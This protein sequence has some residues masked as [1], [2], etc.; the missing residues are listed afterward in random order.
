MNFCRSCETGTGGSRIPLAQ[1]CLSSDNCV[2]RKAVKR[3]LRSI[4]RFPV[5]L[6]CLKTLAMFHSDAVAVTSFDDWAGDF[7]LFHHR[8][9]GRRRHG[10]GYRAHDQ[11]LHRDVALKFLSVDA[12]GDPTAHTNILTEARTISALNHPN[13]CTIYEVGEASGQPYL[14]MEFIEGHTLSLEIT[15]V[16]MAV[17][18]VVRY[19]M[20]L[21]DAL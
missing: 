21:A 5:R 9:I 18:I 10:C 3:Y 8:E 15:S 11:T 4:R 20:Q 6:P 1:F 19:G 12:V 7:A 14:A 2:V 13:I 17:D 16:G